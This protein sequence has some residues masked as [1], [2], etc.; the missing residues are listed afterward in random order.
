[1]SRKGLAPSGAVKRP[2]RPKERKRRFLLYCEGEKTEPS[3]FDGLVRYLR[4][5]LIQ[6]VIGDR[7][8]DPKGL[9]ELAIAHRE[10]AR[11]DAR[12]QNDDSLLFNEVWCIFDVDEHTRLPDAIQKAVVS[13]IDLAISNPCFELWILIH[14]RDQWAFITGAAAQSAVRQFITGYGKTV[15]YS[16]LAGKGEVAINRAQRMALRAE[17]AGDKIGNP[18]TGVWRLVSELCQ[19]ARFPIK[20]L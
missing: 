18:S 15:D 11:R 17:E 10:R 19:H 8:A 13:S 9:V 5:P 7:Q 2:Y 3:Y 20:H 16:L 12:R 4:S 6:I 14:F 1:M